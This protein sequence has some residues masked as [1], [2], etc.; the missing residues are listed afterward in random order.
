MGYVPLQKPIA[1]TIDYRDGFVVCNGDMVWLYPYELAVSLVS[2]VNS[3]IPSASTS[4][5]EQPE[6]RPCCR[7]WSWYVS[8]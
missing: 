4:L 5:R 6:V 3:Q 1:V 2:F 8:N 7:K